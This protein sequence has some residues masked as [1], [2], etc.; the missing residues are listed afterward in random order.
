MSRLIKKLIQYFFI[1]NSFLLSSDITLKKNI[2]SLL[3]TTDI[4]FFSSSLFV[5]T[6]GGL[7]S[8]SDNSFLD[9][10]DKLNTFSLNGLYI[11]NNQM[12]VT[13]DYKG[14]LQIFDSDFNIIKIVNYPLFDSIGKTVFSTDYAYSIVLNDN[15][16]FLAQYLKNND[17]PIYLNSLMNFDLSYNIINDIQIY[18]NSVYIATDNGL[19]SAELE[20]NENNLINSNFWS[21]SY[22]GHSIEKLSMPYFFSNNELINYNTSESVFTANEDDYVIDIGLDNTNIFILTKNKLYTLNLGVL[23]EIVKPN[24]YKQNFS[25]FNILN[26]EIHFGLEDGGILLYVDSLWDI[27]IPNTVFTNKFD[28]IFIKDNNILFGS[29]NHRFE[30]GQS[31]GFIFKNISSDYNNQIKNFYAYESYKINEFPTTISHYTADTLN[32]WSGNKSITSMVVDDDNIYILNNGMYDPNIY[33]QFYIDQS[34]NYGI[35][36]NVTPSINYGGL[37]NLSIPY[38]GN[39]SILNSWNM[40]NVILDG[41]NEIYANEIYSGHLPYMTLNKLLFDN[42]GNLVVLNPYCE[43]YHHP[44][45]IKEKNTG[46]WYHVFDDDNSYIPKDMVVDKHN[47]L[48]IGYQYAL[49]LNGNNNYSPGG[50]KMVE[51]R[52]VQN[53]NDDRWHDDWLNELEGVNIWS[54]D[55]GVDKYNNEIL[56]I[57]TDIGIQ[58]YILY[59]SYSQSG[60]LTVEF[61]PVNNDYYLNDV[62]FKEGNK[63][64]IDNQNNVWVTTS[65]NGIYILSNIENSWIEEISGNINYE[66]YGL[67]SNNVYDLEFDDYG[68]VYVATDMGISIFETSYSKNINPSNISI[69]P[70]PFKIGEHSELLITNVPKNSEIKIMNLSGYLVKDFY[71]GKHDKKLNWNGTDNYGNYLSTGVY[72]VSLYNYDSKSTG[73]G[74]LAIIK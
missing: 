2:T 49:T 8:I 19:L 12:W 74:K 11:D 55:I 32:Y 67:I 44:I 18:N 43:Y 9:H 25:C 48:W 17:S 61:Q 62:T 1:F 40:E 53:Q 10:S 16:Y 13:S 7:Y 24:I 56:W 64:K 5:A 70:N 34:D 66:N 27:F 46:Y 58:G 50:I 6:N 71:L 59:K 22:E 30:N 73:V 57:L 54:I 35:D 65:N 33:F 42:N 60:N 26:D 23:N 68:F 37:L 41:Q 36:L 38:N 63:I 72:L 28:D 3:N 51:I 20:E 21:V 14:M 29:V 69:S 4:E 39:F 45:A 47:N 31:G 15:S 52:E